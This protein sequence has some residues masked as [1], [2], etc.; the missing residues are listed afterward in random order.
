MLLHDRSDHACLF[1]KISQ[2]AN[3]WDDQWKLHRHPKYEFSF[4][5]AS[6]PYQGGRPGDNGYI[7]LQTVGAAQRRATEAKERLDIA[8]NLFNNGLFL[9]TQVLDFLYNIAFIYERSNSIGWWINIGS[10]FNETG[11]LNK[12]TLDDQGRFRITNLLFKIMGYRKGRDY[13]F[14]GN[15]NHCELLKVKNEKEAKDLIFEE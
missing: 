2:S 9:Y 5:G 4:L 15:G 11:E 12:D 3:S 6:L 7:S 1:L 13:Y 14:V 10:N 8:E